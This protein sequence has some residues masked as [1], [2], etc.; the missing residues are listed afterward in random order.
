MTFVKPYFCTDNKLNVVEKSNECA[1][2]NPIP[3]TSVDI[4]KAV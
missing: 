1:S 3:F 2:D 4:S